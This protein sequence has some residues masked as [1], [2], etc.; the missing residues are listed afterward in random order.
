MPRLL[1][2]DYGSSCNYGDKVVGQVVRQSLQ[3]AIPDLIIRQATPVT[4]A[5]SAGFYQAT[6]IMAEMLT[7]DVDAALILG[8][9]I[10]FGQTINTNRWAW[11]KHCQVPVVAWGGM[12]HVDECLAH[13]QK[14]R[15]ILSNVDHRFCRFQGEQVVYNEIGVAAEVG[16][17]PVFCRPRYEGLHGKRLGLCIT[18]P[19]GENHSLDFDALREVNVFLGRIAPDYPR[20]SIL[21]AD[22]R[23][24]SLAQMD[25]RSSV[26]DV[27]GQDHWIEAHIASCDLLV[28]SRLHPAVTA[29]RHGVPVIGIDFADKLRMLLESMNLGDLCV[30]LDTTTAS[31]LTTIHQYIMENREDVVGRVEE[32]AEVMRAQASDTMQKVAALVARH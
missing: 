5:A 2:V 13:G 3:S 19:Y 18:P 16:G 4:D 8:G 29:L 1:I 31:Q 25:L 11:L 30:D 7:K 26:A 12:Q 27:V 24:A 21:R 17:D 20:L 9:S 15:D 22:S 32:A 10:W 28:T 6:D 14:L 23:V